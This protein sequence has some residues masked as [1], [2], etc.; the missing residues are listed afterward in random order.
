MCVTPKVL[1]CLFDVSCPVYFVLSQA[2]ACLVCDQM[3]CKPCL[4]PAVMHA[5]FDVSCAAY[6]NSCTTYLA[7][8]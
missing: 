1:H 6:F 4:I 2:A 3:C 5:L 8:I 7:L